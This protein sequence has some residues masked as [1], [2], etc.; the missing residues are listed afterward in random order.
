MS[1]GRIIV[2]LSIFLVLILTIFVYL[3]TKNEKAQEIIRGY[4]P[5]SK[6]N[7]K[8]MYSQTKINSYEPEPE[9]WPADKFETSNQ[10]EISGH[11]GLLV[12]LNTSHVLF[13]KNSNEK[14][15]IA[16][17]AKIMT[18]VV[19][20][21]HKKLDSKMYVSKKVAGIGENSM[22]IDEGEI[23]TLEELLYGLILHSGNDSAY[24]IAE[25]A[26]GNSDRF[27]EW[28]NFKAKEIGLANT[29]FTD[30]SGLDDSAY[31]TATDLVKLTRYALKDPEF[32]NIVKT[33]EKELTSD[34]HKYIYL[35]NQTN[36]LTTYPGVAGVKTGY[37][38][39]AGLC[40]V[41]YTNNEGKEVVGVVLN[42]IDRKGDMILMLDHGYKTI[43][44][45]VKH[46]LL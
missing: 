13:E 33:V 25:G 29:H 18:A 22:Q 39:E 44:V 28:M 37:T 35:Y 24:A 1:K 40:L 17:L 42:S 32:R 26:A 27:V 45:N 38:E 4:I 16:S 2:G 46:N 34:T 6:I 3:V 23:Y 21:E 10:P 41:T 5:D 14:M 19:A 8:Q 20:L 7:G 36:L 15:K 9:W 12:D 11:S 30:P 31:S 43:G